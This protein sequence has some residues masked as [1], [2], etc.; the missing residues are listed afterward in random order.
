MSIPVFNRFVITLKQQ[1]QHQQQQQQQQQEQQQEQEQEQEQQQQ[2]QPQP[3]PQPQQQQQ[4]EHQQQQQQQQQQIQIMFPGI[5]VLFK[6]NACWLPFGIPTGPL[7][8]LNPLCEGEVGDTLRC[9]RSW[10]GTH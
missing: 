1:H 6:A 3:Q 9:W 7:H 10:G 5:W 8:L 2:Q 4:P